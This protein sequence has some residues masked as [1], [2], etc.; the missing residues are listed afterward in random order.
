MADPLY[1]T[2]RAATNGIPTIY[3]VTYL[4]NPFSPQYELLGRI[5]MA[6]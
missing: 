6:S 3:R 4:A 1:F 5:D 2:D